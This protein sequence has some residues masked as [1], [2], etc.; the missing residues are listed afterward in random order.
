MLSP[1]LHPV[2][3]APLDFAKDDLSRIAELLDRAG[4]RARRS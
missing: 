4:G 1:L 3:T 2:N